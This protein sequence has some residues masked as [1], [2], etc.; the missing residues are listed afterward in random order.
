MA[1]YTTQMGAARKGIITPQMEIVAE[2]EHMAPEQLRELIAKGEVIIPCNKNHKALSPSGVGAKLTTKINVNL[3]VSRDWKDVDMEYEKVR[4][5]VDMGAEAIMDLSSYG[6][7]RTF[8]RKLTETCP[9]M[10]GTVPIYDAVVYYH[11]PLGQITAQE[12]LDIVKMHAE[13]GVD[14]MTIHCGMNR[15]TAQRF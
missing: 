2:K 8:R 6:D 7:T 3:G 11:K 5:A 14:F 15:A 4:A 10:I 13:D 9:A 12:W 1:D